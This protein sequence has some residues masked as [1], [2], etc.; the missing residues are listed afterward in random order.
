MHIWIGSKTCNNVYIMV[1]QRSL[2]VGDIDIEVRLMNG[3]GV[4]VSFCGYM[5]I[6]NPYG[7]WC[8]I[9]KIVS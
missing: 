3:I 9:Q 6:V 5:D 1:L 8:D 2:L 7:L 4:E